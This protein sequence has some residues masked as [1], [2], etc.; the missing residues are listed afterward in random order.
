V[1]KYLA[2]VFVLYLFV[3]LQAAQLT[4]LVVTDLQVISSNLGLSRTI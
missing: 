1:S 2:L 3:R 4:I